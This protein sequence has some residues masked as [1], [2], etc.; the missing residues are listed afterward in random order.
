MEET[1]KI[2]VTAKE[3]AEMLDVSVAHAYKL[4]RKMN[5]DLAQE[6]YIVIS[7]KVPRRYLEK[8]WYGFLA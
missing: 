6:G 8:R 4:I 5:D 3:L 2:Y 1:K 7:G